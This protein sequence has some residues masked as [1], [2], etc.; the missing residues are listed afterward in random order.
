MTIREQKRQNKHRPKFSDIESNVLS[1][2][3]ARRKILN[4]IKGT[5]LKKDG[6]KFF[7]MQTGKNNFT[8]AYDALK[9]L[10]SNAINTDLKD[11]QNEKLLA[12]LASDT[13]TQLNL[14]N[15]VNLNTYNMK[16]SKMKS[17]GKIHNYS[18]NRNYQSVNTNEV[19][20]EPIAKEPLISLKGKRN[21]ASRI[22]NISPHKGSQ[23][24]NRIRSSDRDFDCKN[25][26][27]DFMT[28]DDLQSE[29]KLPRSKSKL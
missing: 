24:N 10:S 5:D 29:Q 16:T 2:K 14:V 19:K 21:S 11:F 20:I 25:K 9:Y 27:S 6:H 26:L 15:R 3:P 18:K 13:P 4:E 1:Q 17:V 23:S 28:L 12:K 7:N 22:S 8:E